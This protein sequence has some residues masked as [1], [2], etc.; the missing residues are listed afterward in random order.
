MSAITSIVTG[1]K[2]ASA[3]KKQRKAL[4]AKEAAERESN[5]VDKKRNAL[6]VQREKISALR[7]ARIKRAQIIQGTANSGA[8]YSGTSSA[9]GATGSIQS[10]LGQNI[11]RLGTFEGFGDRLSLLSQQAADQLSKYN[12]IGSKQA[13]FSGMMGAIGGA[14]DAA[15]AAMGGPA[16]AAAMGSKALSSLSSSFS[17]SSSNG[18]W[19][20]ASGMTSGSGPSQI[21]TGTTNKGFSAPAAQARGS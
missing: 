18:A 14:G 7:E 6:K 8:I 1:I 10:Q 12:R 19:G 3:A 20:G 13:A 17:S 11:G 4:A 2:G 21:A 16:G 5:R 15:L 9:T